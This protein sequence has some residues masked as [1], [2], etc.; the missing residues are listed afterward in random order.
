M[1]KKALPKWELARYLIDA[2]KNVDTVIFIEKYSENLYEFPHGNLKKAINEFCNSTCN[3][4]DNIGLNKKDLCASEELINTVYTERDKNVSHKDKDYSK[5]SFDSKLMKNVLRKVKRIA[6]D[7]LPQGLTL[8]FL[9]WDPI[10]FRMMRGISKEDEFSILQKQKEQFNKMGEILNINF[11]FDNEDI[12]KEQKKV[13][14]QIEKP[15]KKRTGNEVVIFKNGLTTD[16]GLQIRQDSAIALNLTFDT[17]IWPRPNKPSNLEYK[18]M[19]DEGIID[20]YGIM[21]NLK[22]LTIYPRAQFIE[23]PK[24]SKQT[25]TITFYCELFLSFYLRQQ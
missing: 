3:V 16:E 6:K 15:L 23:I 7:N 1:S 13:M 17:N 4:L 10:L 24:I 14:N 20:E 2:K 8:N 19:K 5:I 21:K 18:K 22:E 11:Q 9:C 25:K 12:I